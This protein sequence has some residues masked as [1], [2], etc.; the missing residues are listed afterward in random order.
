MVIHCKVTTSFP[1]GLKPKDTL[2]ELVKVLQEVNEVE[3]LKNWRTGVVNNIAY[4]KSI[5]L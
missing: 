4:T 2:S 3:Q 1:N 5:W